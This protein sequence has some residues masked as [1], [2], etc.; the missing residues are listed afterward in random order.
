MC[1]VRRN[2]ILIRIIAQHILVSLVIVS[3][4]DQD[5]VKFL[6]AYLVPSFDVLNLHQCLFSLSLPYSGMPSPLDLHTSKIRSTHHQMN[7]V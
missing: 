1:G 4:P 7:N 3:Q 5:I 6:Q 2:H